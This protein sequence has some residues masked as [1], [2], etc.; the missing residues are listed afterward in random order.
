M[1]L[2]E[3]GGPSSFDPAPAAAKPDFA[4]ISAP[5]GI[6]YLESFRY[7]FAHPDW[8]KNLIIFSVFILI[9]VLNIAIL[10][11]YMYEIVEHRHRRLPGPY[12]LFEIRHFARYVTRGIWGYL[13]ADIMG[14]IIGPVVQVLTQST[15]FGSMAAIQS[16]DA[17]AIAAAVIIPLVI[18][19]F[20]LFVI[21]LQ[22][23]ASPFFLRGG[24]TQ[25]FG[26][27]MKF[28]WALDFVQRTWIE[29]ILIHIFVMLS[30]AV[31]LLLGCLLFCYGMLVALALATIVEAHLYCQLY[32]LY[33]ARGGEPIPLKPLP[34][35]V[36]PV[37]AASG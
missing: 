13:L 26:L 1:S 31:L 7:V 2:P 18:I 24:L 3:T 34:A 15:M 10:F 14:V 32:E 27:M 12:P 35:D 8:L 16:G 5:T 19:A 6:Q 23:V 11:G 25:D 30:T 37:A 36:P 4:P 22:I 20:L 33:L 17:G 9:P 28:R 29:L 21:G